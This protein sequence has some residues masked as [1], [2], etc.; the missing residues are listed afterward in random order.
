[1]GVAAAAALAGLGTAAGLRLDHFF[2][3]E[4]VEAKGRVMALALSSPC[5]KALERGKRGLPTDLEA[6]VT[7]LRSERGIM[8]DAELDLVSL[9]VTDERGQVVLSQMKEGRDLSREA[10]DAVSSG[11]LVVTEP[12]NRW[13]PKGEAL[14]EFAAPLRAEGKTSGVLWFALSLDRARTQF[15]KNMA[16]LLGAVGLGALAF[17]FVLYKALKL[18]IL[19]PI[20]ELSRGIERVRSGDLTARVAV[21]RDDEIATVVASFNDMVAMLRERP[22]LEQKVDEAERLEAAHRRLAAAHR[23]LAEAHAKLQTTQEELVLTE[24]QASLGRLVKSVAHE[25]KNPLNAA[26]NSL[27]SLESS[28]ARM[29]ESFAKESAG[30]A[31][32]KERQDEDQRDV[33][34][35]L[36]VIQRSVSRA[37]SIIHDL[38]GF[39]QLGI[40]DLVATDLRRVIDDAAQ[41][42]VGV[43]GGRIRLEVDVAGEKDEPIVLTAFPTLLLQVFVNLFTNAA[44]AIKGSGT[45]TVWARVRGD[46][47]LLE[48]KDTGPGI[49]KEH[50]ARL[51]EPFFTTKGVTGTGLGLALTYAYVEKHGGTI[52][53]RSEPGK[54]ATFA[55][56]LPLVARPAR[57]LGPRASAVFEGA[58]DSTQEVARGRRGG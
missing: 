13:G 40:A 30:T 1:M 17:W 5:A 53:A 27:P 41:S 24:K 16:E 50:M 31:V 47:V 20:L 46:R 26:A 10:Q 48:V 55:I 8:G 42:C 51:F 39:S 2:R 21:D 43:F 19:R 38:Q 37:V 56:D 34:S 23:E 3:V 18:R 6:I 9:A 14:L 11:K 25:L 49:E 7:D 4:V 29:R 22:Q 32:E 44:Q 52:E 28:L 33:E 15:W 58:H 57:E 45:I 36:A 12:T 35:A 54:G